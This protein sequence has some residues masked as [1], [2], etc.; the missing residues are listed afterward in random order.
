MTAKLASHPNIDA[1]ARSECLLVGDQHHR[2]TG[3]ENDPPAELD[4]A[5]PGQVAVLDYRRLGG[6][7]DKLKIL[8]CQRAARLRRGWMVHQFR[9]GDGPNQPRIY[10]SRCLGQEIWDRYGPEGEAEGDAATLLRIIR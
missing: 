3:F 4:V 7:L 1:V 6:E 2:T 10:R 5:R 8:G 9:D